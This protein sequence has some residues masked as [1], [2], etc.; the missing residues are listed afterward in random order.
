MLDFVAPYTPYTLTVYA[1]SFP[2]PVRSQDS[3]RGVW[4][5]LTPTG[6]P[7]ARF[8]QLL[9]AH[10]YAK[11]D[12]ISFGRCRCWVGMQQ[13]SAH[14]FIRAHKDRIRNGNAHCPGRSEIDCQF[15]PGNYFHRQ[16]T[17]LGALQ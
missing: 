6:L 8:R 17:G 2:L 4:L 12:P 10:Q 5:E 7:P 11:P 1:S 9:L 15:D 16:F 3:L 14:H 13:L